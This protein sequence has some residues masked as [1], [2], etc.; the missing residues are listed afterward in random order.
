M[1]KPV[2][3]EARQEL[4]LGTDGLLALWRAVEKNGQ[5]DQAA[6][7][8]AGGEGKPQAAGLEDNIKLQN[9]VNYRQQID[10]LNNRYNPS[11]PASQKGVQVKDA[12]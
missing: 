6:N 3:E 2:D 5:Q 10:R 7:A 8:P 9:S 12:Y 11:N 1:T 4:T